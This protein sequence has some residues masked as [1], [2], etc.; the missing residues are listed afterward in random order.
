M[1]SLFPTLVVSI[2]F[3]L[4]AISRRAHLQ[5]KRLIRERVAYMLWEMAQQT[6]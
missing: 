2:I 4:W 6:D 1:V 5:R 3:C